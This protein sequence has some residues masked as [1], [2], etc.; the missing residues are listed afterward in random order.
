MKI[1]K[2]LIIIFIT[3]AVFTSCSIVD[4]DSSVVEDEKSIDE[5]RFSTNSKIGRVG[6]DIPLTNSEMVR[7]IALSLYD[8]DTIEKYSKEGESDFNLINID[9]QEDVYKYILALA[10]QDILL[11]EN[12][13]FI[14]DKIVT[15]GELDFILKNI[16]PEGTFTLKVEDETKD[17]NVSYGFF[18]EMMTKTLN[19]ISKN[20]IYNKFKI[21]FNEEVVLATN[22]Q[23]K[24]IPKNYIVTDY[25]VNK[26][27][28][29]N[30]S[31]FL[32][33]S[34]KIM[35]R[36]DEVIYIT[37]VLS[38]TP[39]IKSAY[40][41]NNTPSKISVFT[42]GVNRI[43]N[44]HDGIAEDLS[45]K[46]CDIR[47]DG[48]DAKE[49][50]VLG[51]EIL[52]EI[53][54]IKSDKILF[55]EN[56]VIDIENNI[57][58]LKFYDVSGN[59]VKYKNNSV[60]YVGE[61]DIKFVLSNDKIVGGIVLKE[62][63]YKDVRVLINNSDF[64][65][66]K[67]QN[68]KFSGSLLVNGEEYSSYEVNSND[69]D[70]FEY[71]TIKSV[72]NSEIYFDSINRNVS[73]GVPRYYGYIDVIKTPYGLAVVNDLPIEKY[74]EK[75]VP[76]EMPSN[77]NSE[78]LKAQ[79]VSARTYAVKQI[80]DKI[81]QEYGASI[82]DSVLS[83][84]YNN[85]DTTENTTNAVNETFGEVLTYN[86]EVVTTNFFST[87]SGFTSNSGEVWG[88]S[89]TMTY[90][91]SSPEYLTSQ[92]LLYDAIT[93]D[94]E[95]EDELLQYFKDTSLQAVDS[96]VSWFRWDVS[97]DFDTILNNINNFI[98]SRYNIASYL[99]DVE[100]EF[101]ENHN[102]GNI[103]Y[104]NVKKRGANGLIT[105]LEVVGDKYTLI[106]RG[107][108]NIRKVLAPKSNTITRLDGSKIDNYNILP[109]GYFAFEKGQQSIKIYGGGNGHGVGL[110][111]N[112]ANS[113]G[114]DGKDYKEI[115]STFY[116]NT[117]LQ[118]LWE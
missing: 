93:Y 105:E 38:N 42:G 72:D 65:S 60:V 57:S 54:L 31:S 108:Y 91:I 56:G 16:N 81:F 117:E 116:T 71:I 24:D 53:K 58:S 27:S 96:N 30:F 9:K 10:S 100:D 25:G 111:Q 12:D 66:Y 82:D 73:G 64:S 41:V 63:S 36:N 44:V 69:L 75:V 20:N 52:D 17:L 5:E 110:S 85:I 59:K 7:I 1:I 34:I 101:L 86:D 11:I 95:D 6:D 80:N 50:V 32:N 8:E 115:L 55:A 39:T 97:I 26:T 62:K 99:I 114:K 23:N 77:Y 13:E 22:M 40:I 37:E 19:D 109:S 76:S 47:I 113:L 49:V 84:V 94:L 103:K 87:S 118:N 61:S 45:G 89:K 90:P 48:N 74:L 88:N 51:N 4:N 107:E 3:I 70:E 98:P 83:Q 14:T 104:I 106:V 21:S 112:G 18:T 15:L 78:A 46:L 29:F 33:H 35:K 43:Y 67:F 102:F 92:N 79:A 68:V 28:F 2:R